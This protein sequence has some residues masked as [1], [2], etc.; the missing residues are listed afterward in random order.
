MAKRMNVKSRRS[1]LFSKGKGVDL[2]FSGSQ[3]ATAP[4]QTSDPTLASSDPADALSDDVEAALDREADASRGAGELSAFP[5]QP[6][7]GTTSEPVA[8]PPAAATRSASGWPPELAINASPA[9]PA[10][11][12]PF[13]EN[14]MDMGLPPLPSRREEPGMLPPELVAGLAPATD[15]PP[16]Q[17]TQ[18]PGQ[19]V[20]DEGI[21]P[22]PGAGTGPTKSADIIEKGPA[23]RPGGPL[24]P[25]EPAQP[26]PDDPGVTTPPEPEPPI[27]APHPITEPAMPAQPSQPAKPVSGVVETPA[28]PQPGTVRP[29]TGVI[30]GLRTVG[31]PGMPASGP[32]GEGVGYYQANDGRLSPVLLEREPGEMTE[33][34]RRLALERIDPADLVALDQQVDE[35]YERVATVM[36]GERE[37]EIAFSTLRKARQILLLRPEWFAEAEYLIQQI[38]ASLNRIQQSL[39]AGARFGPRLLAYQFVWLLLLGGFAVLT[40]VPDNV[41]SR[42]VAYLMDV[43]AN[44]EGLVWAM[45]FLS[46]LCWGGI[47]GVTSALWSL[48]YHVSVARDFDR[49]EN[50]WYL[51]Q[52]VLGMVLG[53]I[54]YLI[55]ASGFLVVNAQLAGTD[56]AL[57]A[58]LLPAA[59]AIVAGFRQTVVLDLIERV[60]KLLA[61]APGDEGSQ[62]PS[63]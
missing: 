14:E 33:E 43:D 15:A 13:T 49:V 31:A 51:E 27:A 6:A 32:G 60:V 8:S 40:T 55:M 22:R 61:P 3:D 19:I 37:A 57:G 24:P 45:L 10:A 34:E 29:G 63:I 18:P 36:S 53:G 56:A 21:P 59:I 54:V 28:E 35:L 62:G 2:L 11:G 7:A 38:N 44:S 9:G 47:G 17:A 25:V 26:R 23:P 20:A 42:W 16:P 4:E 30:V 5:R 58:R 41:F 46:T 1:Q 50:I 52:P 39:E 48:H 12:A